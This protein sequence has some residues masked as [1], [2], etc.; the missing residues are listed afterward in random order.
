MHPGITFPE[1]HEDAD[2]AL[3]TLQEHGVRISIDI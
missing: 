3:A 2:K 1:R